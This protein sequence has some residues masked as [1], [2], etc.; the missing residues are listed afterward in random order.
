MFIN[1]HVI[2]VSE[3]KSDFG[4]NFKMNLRNGKIALH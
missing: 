3:R 1:D 4:E 2:D